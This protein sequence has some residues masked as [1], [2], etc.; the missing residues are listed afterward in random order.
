[1]RPKLWT[2]WTTTNSDY[3]YKAFALY[4][5]TG[6]DIANNG[7]HYV[8][9]K[10]GADGVLTFTRDGAASIVLDC[11]NETL[12]PVLSET[13]DDRYGAEYSIVFEAL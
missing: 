7:Y 8:E 2:N 10:I 5:N 9:I 3:K 13:F 11:P 6:T 4:F 1:M 12:G